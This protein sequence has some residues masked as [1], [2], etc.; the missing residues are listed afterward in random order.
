K[1]TFSP[2]FRNRL[3]ARIHFDPLTPGVMERVVDKFVKE[4]GE[5][6]S[7]RDVTISLTSSARAYLADK[8]Y[9]KDQGARPLARLIQDEIKKP[10]GDELLFGDLEHGG[11]VIVDQKDGALVF[12]KQARPSK[13]SDGPKL[14]N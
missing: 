9:D 13:A 1:N 4:L 12:E 14:L 2:E 3:D 8:G 6:L 7:E 5:Q 10:L 11:H